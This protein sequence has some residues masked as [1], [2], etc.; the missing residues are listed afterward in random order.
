MSQSLYGGGT[1]G[2]DCGAVLWTLLLLEREWAAGLGWGAY[3]LTN[4]VRLPAF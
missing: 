1:Q 4:L 3:F 2:E